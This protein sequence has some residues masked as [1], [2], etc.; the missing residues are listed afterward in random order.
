M[1]SA[2]WIPIIE[3]LGVGV[4]VMGAFVA[5]QAAADAQNTSDQLWRI[6][7][8]RRADEEL[9]DLLAT[10]VTDFFSG[11]CDLKLAM[12][13]FPVE[14]WFNATDVDRQFIEDRCQPPGADTYVM[15][16]LTVIGSPTASHSRVLVEFSV[17]NP[18]LEEE[19]RSAVDMTLVRDD[20]GDLKIT[21]I[22]EAIT[23]AETNRG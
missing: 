18:D 1:I 19:A 22:T 12:Y 20:D 8:A 4:T 2:R 15:R 23:P 5:C 16:D 11:D 21:R 17:G 3:L 13:K 14:R 9:E 10:Q 7:D 6:E